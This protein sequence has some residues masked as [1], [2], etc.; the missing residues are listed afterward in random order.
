MVRTI[1]DES[2]IPHHSLVI[3]T[4]GNLT[5][6]MEI[7]ITSLG[8]P[9]VAQGVKDPALPQLWYRLKL[10]LGLDPWPR[11]FH[12]LW[13]WPKKKKKKS[14]WRNKQYYSPMV[15]CVLLL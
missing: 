1:L 2:D 5:L 3:I 14:P 7:K 8:V 15:I 13:V 4:A 10:K 9:V 11:N 12:V 6:A